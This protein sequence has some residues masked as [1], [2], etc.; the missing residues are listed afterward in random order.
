MKRRDAAAAYADELRR[1]ARRAFLEGMR[2]ENSALAD[3]FRAMA[4]EYLAKAERL[5]RTMSEGPAQGD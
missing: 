2:P 3:L 4:R 1:L 5:S